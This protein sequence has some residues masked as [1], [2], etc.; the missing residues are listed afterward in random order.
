M[1]V[2]SGRA[3]WWMDGIKLRKWEETAIRGTLQNQ[4]IMAIMTAALDHTFPP[5]A[6]QTH[7]RHHQNPSHQTPVRV[8]ECVCIYVC[9][10]V[11]V[12]EGE[13]ERERE[14]ERDVHMHTQAA[15]IVYLKL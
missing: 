12:C 11:F 2:F 13:R 9:V 14:R 10:C 4:I 5:F 3:R 1:V 8:S 6:Y 15:Y 7:C